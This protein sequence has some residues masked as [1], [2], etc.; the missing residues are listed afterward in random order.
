ML[1]RSVITT[2]EMIR[3]RLRIEA[4][5]GPC[6]QHGS[7]AVRTIQQIAGSLLMVAVDQ[8]QGSADHGKKGTLSEIDLIN[9]LLGEQMTLNQP[10]NAEVIPH[11]QVEIRLTC[12]CVLHG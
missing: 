10:F 7:I 3:S 2:V 12:C 5:A 6:R 8:K 9:R 11:Q 4:V 1:N